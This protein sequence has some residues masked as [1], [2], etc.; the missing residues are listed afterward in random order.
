[1]VIQLLMTSVPGSWGV[2]RA[3]IAP[4][5]SLYKCNALEAKC[6]TVVMPVGQQ[7]SYPGLALIHQK[8]TY[9]IFSYMQYLA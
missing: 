7:W 5:K 9:L 2:P 4:R 8:Y 3:V 6:E 1:M